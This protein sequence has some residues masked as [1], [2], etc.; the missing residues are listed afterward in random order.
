MEKIRIAQIGVTHEH[1][2]GKMLSLKAMPNIFEIAGFVNDL[3][4]TKTP[5]LVETLHPCFDGLKPLTLDKALNDPTI[6]AVTVEV[7]NNELVPCA[8]KFAEKGI[9]IHMD[10]PA[11]EDLT[12]Y[13]KLLS[14]CK[15][16]NVPFQ[17]G[18]MFRGNPA[19]QF[20]LRAIREKWIG[21]V[22]FME[23]DMNHCYGGEP[24][25]EYL[26]KFPGGI[27]YNLGC[28]LIDFV[29]AAMGRPERISPFLKSAPSYPDAIKNNCMAVFEYPHA[30]AVIAA[31]SKTSG[32]VE[33][34]MCR[35]IGN[36]GSIEF[37]PLER[38]NGDAIEMQLHLREGND[39]YP[40]GKHILKFQPQRDRYAVQL[41]ELAEIIRGQKQ[42]PY[43]YDHDALV[44]EVTLAAAGIIP[45]NA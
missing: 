17:M 43:S 16:K 45:W 26:G 20:C 13:R 33:S 24:Y 40:T 44:H 38:F 31:C 25:Q 27:M 12:L 19:F 35:I 10:K 28:H 39:V 5:R 21:E 18:F 8:M 30:F 7:P 4:L 36:K 22:V 15:A 37:S 23:A 34:R 11:G 9:A 1:A 32:N 14:L 6:Q 42:N 2:S 29:V 41:T 3:A